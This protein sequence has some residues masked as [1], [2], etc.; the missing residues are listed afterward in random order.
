M[1]AHQSPASNGA[2]EE[3]YEAVP[4]AELLS[5]GHDEGLARVRTSLHQVPTE[6][7]GRLAIVKAE[8]ETSKGLFEAYGDA[9]P[10][11]VE[12]RFVPHLI[13]VAETRAK[14]RALRD[15]VNCGIASLEE[16][17]GTSETTNGGPGP[18]AS[19]RQAFGLPVRSQRSPAPPRRSP[20]RSAPQSPPPG[21]DGPMS[22]AQRRYL[23]RILAGHGY[24]GRDAEDFLR[25]KLGVAQL[26]L[27]TRN[28]ASTLID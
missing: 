22:E 18:G 3:S 1:K 5:R 6:D 13:R 26:S 16:L 19:M 23:F 21:E 15:A 28:E 11:S 27:A 10:T 20:E 9:D 2:D 7:N 4:Y 25:Q 17:D 8:I 12:E 24:K 14:A